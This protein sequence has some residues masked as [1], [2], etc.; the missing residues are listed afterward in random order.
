L[1]FL[2]V[3]NRDASV[4]FS[5][6]KVKAPQHTPQVP[7]MGQFQAKSRF[8]VPKMGHLSEFWIA[9]SIKGYTCRNF[10]LLC[11]ERQPRESEITD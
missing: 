4:L 9:S 1:K 10:E 7:K 5:I 8:F 11:V 3:A 6:R 2:I